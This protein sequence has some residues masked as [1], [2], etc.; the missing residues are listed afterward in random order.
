MNNI[1]IMQVVDSLHLGGMEAVAVNLANSLSRRGLNSY[2]CS[3]RG[4][5]PLTSRLRDEVKAVHLERKGFVGLAGLRRMTRFIRKHRIGL[6]HAHGSALFFSVIAGFFCPGVKVIWHA[7]F[8]RFATEERASWLYRLA[9][10]HVAGVIAVNQPLADWA[11]FRLHVPPGRVW[12]LPNFVP[13]P[14]GGELSKGLPGV[15]GKRIVCVA[16]LR[17]EKDHLNLIA[18]ME[19]LR[20]SEPA[21]TL[22]L[23]GSEANQQHAS[24]VRAAI[25]QRGLDS[26]VFLLG[27]RKDIPS[28]LSAC[29]I[30]V[31]SSASEGM[32]LAIL[33]YA[34]AGLATVATRVGQIPEVLDEGRAGTL[35]PPGHPK[36]LS[37]ALLLML[38]SVDLRARLGGELHRWVQKKYGETA[39]INQLVR[40]YATILGNMKEIRQ[41]PQPDQNTTS[42]SKLS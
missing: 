14:C 29:D 23:V 8:G 7:H 34:M 40:I 33:E 42:V 15:P 2:L 31:L 13:E 9:T 12:Y 10:R 39:L 16:N 28:I 21:A 22:L 17:P 4:T 3:T 18:A 1:A 5:G 41:S 26:Q 11:K 25:Q 32:P 35:V 30:G 36:E 24:R 6:L 37:Q 20:M 19:Q 38:R 27:S